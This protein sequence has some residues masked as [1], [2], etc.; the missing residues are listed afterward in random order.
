MVILF[1]KR[2]LPDLKKIKDRSILKRIQ[3][4]AE[5]VEQIVDSHD[6]SS[7]CPIL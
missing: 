3:S 1:E 5:E 4:L 7:R 6:S 2:F